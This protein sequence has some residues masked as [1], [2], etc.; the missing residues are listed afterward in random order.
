ME[1][2]VF[3]LSH[4]TCFHWHEVFKV[5]PR[6]STCQNSTPFDGCVILYYIHI[7]FCLSIRVSMHIRVVSTFLLLWIMLWI[8]MYKDQC[9]SLLST[10]GPS[11]ALQTSQL[12]PGIISSN[13]SM[14]HLSRSATW[15]WVMFQV[16]C[17]DFG[18]MLDFSLPALFAWNYILLREGR[19]FLLLLTSVSTHFHTWAANSL[20]QVPSSK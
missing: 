18:C 4:L 2:H 16:T 19:S 5:H 20:H 8:W 12:H 14:T 6:S 3:A 15:V 7:T 11:F 1:S 13:V 10:E 17:W 9:K